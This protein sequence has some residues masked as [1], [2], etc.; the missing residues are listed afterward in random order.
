MSVA[1]AHTHPL[2]HAK[3]PQSNFKK[4][5]VDLRE[6][7]TKMVV[8]VFHTVDGRN[9]AYPIIYKVVY[10]PGGRG[11]L[12]STAFWHS[13]QPEKTTNTKLLPQI[14]KGLP[15]RKPTYPLPAG[16]FE[17][18]VPFPKVGYVTFVE[19]IG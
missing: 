14:P 1:L 11:F 16:T 17:D 18:D 13:Y 8:L 10:I 15:S 6:S 4:S 7:E 2:P 19:G 5:L 12:P 3:I 9:P